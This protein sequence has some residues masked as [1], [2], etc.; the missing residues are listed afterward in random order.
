LKGNETVIVEFPVQV[1]Q[2][3]LAQAT[4]IVSQTIL[5]LC[6]TVLGLDGAV[7]SIK[8]IVGTNVK[9]LVSNIGLLIIILVAGID[10]VNHAQADNIALKR[11]IFSTSSVSLA[12]ADLLKNFSFVIETT[13]QSDC[14]LIYGILD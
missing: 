9:Y 5:Y 12:H 13:F 4:I 6:L 11:P 3:S 1:V 2:Y 8:D 7:P 14:V 10:Q